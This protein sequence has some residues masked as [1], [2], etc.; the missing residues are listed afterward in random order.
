LYDI[1]KIH[2]WFEAQAVDFHELCAPNLSS[3]TNFFSFLI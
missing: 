2:K 1:L 3:F